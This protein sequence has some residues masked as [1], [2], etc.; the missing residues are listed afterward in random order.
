MWKRPVSWKR[1]ETSFNKKTG[2]RFVRKNE[3]DA[4]EQWYIMN[5]FTLAA[6]NKGMLD[7]FPWAGPVWMHIYLSFHTPKNHWPGKEFIS[8]PDIDNL[9]KQILD[10]LTPP[11]VGGFGAYY[12]DAQVTDLVCTKRYDNRGDIITVRLFLFDQVARPMKR[13][14]P[15]GHQT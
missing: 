11:G 7:V 13:R 4:E 10:S 15:D 8:R 9:G 2:A 1:P 3:G 12:D 5:Q 14:K 6:S